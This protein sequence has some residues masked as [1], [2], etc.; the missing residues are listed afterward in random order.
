MDTSGSMQNKR[1]NLAEALIPFGITSPPG[2]E[3]F[4]ITFGD[5][6]EVRVAPTES[7]QEI[8]IGMSNLQS[9]GRTALLDALY[10]GLSQVNASTKARKVLVVLSDGGDNASRYLES[11]IREFVRESEVQVYGLGIFEPFA[12]RGRAPEEMAGPSL[13]ADLAELTGGRS[14]TVDNLREL[15]NFAARVAV[16]LRSQYILGYEPTKT[17]RDGKW[18]K[19]KVKVSPPKELRGLEA[20]TRAGYYAPKQ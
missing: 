4:L 14:F 19:I 6:A 16:E 10:L 12:S 15:P 2:T 3:F 8:M 1:A 5:V 13:L 20:R 11:D 17:A 7:F 9:K 18:R